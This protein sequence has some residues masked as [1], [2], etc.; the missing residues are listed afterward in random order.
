MERPKLV[1]AFFTAG[2]TG[3]QFSVWYDMQFRSYLWR[4]S[5]YF[6]RKENWLYTMSQN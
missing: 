2:E 3:F 6:P 4:F 5:L 1:I